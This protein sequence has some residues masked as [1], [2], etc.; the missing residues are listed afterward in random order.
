MTNTPGYR[1]ANPPGTFSSGPVRYADGIVNLGTNDLES[2][3]FG[4]AW[5]Q[6]RSWSNNTGIT[7]T[8]INGSGWII[9]QLPY[10]VLANGGND[11]LVITNGTNLRDFSVNGSTFTEDAFLLDQLSY[12]STNHEYTLVDTSGNQLKFSDWSSGIPVNQQGQFKS[13]TD[14]DGNVTQVTSRA[15]N[16]NPTEVQRSVT[17]G[18]TTTTESTATTKLSPCANR[19]RLS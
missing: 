10:L 14:A 5:G 16:G 11:I 3:G 2:D 15:T 9:S 6:T 7:G 18:S 4:Q 12:S 8:A 13:L 17:I 1:D 19:P